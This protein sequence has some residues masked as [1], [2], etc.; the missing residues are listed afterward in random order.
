M[1]S[2]GMVSLIGSAASRVGVN[3]GMYPHAPA[4]MGRKT[5]NSLASRLQG[6]VGQDAHPL[7]AG[8]GAVDS[9]FHTLLRLVLDLNAAVLKDFA[10]E[11]RIAQTVLD[12]FD[13]TNVAGQSSP[14]FP[15]D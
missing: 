3:G 14:R 7:A 1:P 9:I 2:G 13:L 6:A 4:R 10:E 15:A 11:H 8:K 12:S 5:L